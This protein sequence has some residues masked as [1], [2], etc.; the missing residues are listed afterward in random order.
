MT[1]NINLSPAEAHAYVVLTKLDPEI[2]AKLEAWLIPVRRDS[3][4]TPMYS[5]QQPQTAT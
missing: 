1:N 3:S 5:W 2:R 4:G